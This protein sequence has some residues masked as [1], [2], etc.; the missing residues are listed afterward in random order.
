MRKGL[1]GAAW[2]VYA[3]GMTLDT[4]LNS[5]SRAWSLWHGYGR[6]RPWYGGKRAARQA[7]EG[8]RAWRRARR[9]GDRLAVGLELALEDLEEAADREDYLDRTYYDDYRG[10]DPGEWWAEVSVA[11]AYAA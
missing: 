5:E 11:G 6:K 3:P 8:K 4:L 1:T 10:F 9:R 2:L 7:A